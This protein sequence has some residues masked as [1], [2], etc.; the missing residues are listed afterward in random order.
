MANQAARRLFSIVRALG[1]TRPGSLAGGAF[2]DCQVYVNGAT[3]ELPH[4]TEADWKKS[5]ER[6]IGSYLRPGNNKISVSVTNDNG[7]PALWLTIAL[8]GRLLATDREWDVSLDGAVLRS[9]VPSSQPLELRPGNPL[10]GGEGTIDSLRRRWGTLALFAI[11][12]SLLGL[13]CYALARKLPKSWFDTRA[14]VRLAVV[15]GAA[16]WCFLLWNNLQTLLFPIGFD[17]DQHLLYIRYIMQEKA[18]PLADEGWESHQPPLYYLVSAGALGLLGLSIDD[19]ATVA[20]LRVFAFLAVMAQIGL[21]A[22]SLRIL[23]PNKPAA[24][25]SGVVLTAFLP[26]HFYLAHY[27]GN[28]LMAGVL[29]SG[30]IYLCLSVLVNWRASLVRLFFSACSWGPRY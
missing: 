22:A 16:L 25:V 28:D 24:Q 9:A 12:A 11:V 30:A 5:R 29:A 23:F 14:P 8:P 7:P 21:V 10:Y 2:T 17:A 20:V 15:V 3:V 27:V 6:Q 26:V 1:G 19:T 13:V 4:D 18:L